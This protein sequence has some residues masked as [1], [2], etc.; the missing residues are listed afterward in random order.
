MDTQVIDGALSGGLNA[1]LGPI[2]KYF[3]NNQVVMVDV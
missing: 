3:K 2:V 1:F